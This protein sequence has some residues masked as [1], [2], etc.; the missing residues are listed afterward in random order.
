[1]SP[2]CPTELY[3][4]SSQL[5][6]GSGDLMEFLSFYLQALINR[7]E[8]AMRFSMRLLLLYA[9]DNQGLWE[10]RSARARGKTVLDLFNRQT[11]LVGGVAQLQEI[12]KN[13]S[14]GF[15]LFIVPQRTG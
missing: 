1:M 7:F 4:N 13:K 8:P 2:V 5:Y 10:H 9:P 14:T 11:E 3:L 6:N 12:L 15:L